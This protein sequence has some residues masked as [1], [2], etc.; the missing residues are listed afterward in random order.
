MAVPQHGADYQVETEGCLLLRRTLRIDDNPPSFGV[1]NATASRTADHC[2]LGAD[3]GNVRESQQLSRSCHETGT[4]F[5]VEVLGGAARA[6]FLERRVCL[7]VVAVAPAG[8]GGDQ[9]TCRDPGESRS[10]AGARG[11]RSQSRRQEPAS[12]ASDRCESIN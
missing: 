6:E 9:P 11:E 4:E 7:C 3:A 1:D 8:A 5:F 10:G 12:A 2:A